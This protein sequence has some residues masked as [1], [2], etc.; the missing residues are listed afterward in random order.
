MYMYSPGTRTPVYMYTYVAKNKL[1]VKCSLYINNL[2][3]FWYRVLV[4][5][6]K[7]I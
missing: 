6:Y 5:G 2:L 4:P 3:F 1:L 7:Q